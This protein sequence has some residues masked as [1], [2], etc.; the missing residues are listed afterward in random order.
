MRAGPGTE[1]GT[2]TGVGGRLETEGADV[3]ETGSATVAPAAAGEGAWA[4]SAKADEPVAINKRSIKMRLVKG[5]AASLY[6][7]PPCVSRTPTP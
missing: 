5:M 2:G 6:L 3:L 1:A 4:G 7:T